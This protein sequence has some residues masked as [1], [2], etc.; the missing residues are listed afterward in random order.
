MK[1]IDKLWIE[2][3]LYVGD[4][5]VEDISEYMTKISEN[6]KNS[7]KDF[8]KFRNKCCTKCSAT[9][10]RRKFPPQIRTKRFLV[11]HQIRNSESN[12]NRNHGRKPNQSCEQCFK[13]KTFFVCKTYS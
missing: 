12:Q 1:D 10:N 13:V 9:D 4:M 3:R 8:C 5:H 2:F 11:N 6:I 7:C